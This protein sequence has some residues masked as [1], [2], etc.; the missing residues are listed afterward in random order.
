MAGHQETG[1]EVISLA[2]WLIWEIFPWGGVGEADP[3]PRVESHPPDGSRPSPS[4]PCHSGYQGRGFS[5]NLGIII[6]AWALWSWKARD[7]AGQHVC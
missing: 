6:K 7:Q 2:Q 1:R 3:R 5:K 4:L